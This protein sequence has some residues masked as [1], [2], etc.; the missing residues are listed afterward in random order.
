MVKRV[1]F[2]AGNG[3]VPNG[4]STPVDAFMLKPVIVLALMFAAYKNCPDGSIVKFPVPALTWKGE[5]LVAAK[6]PL[7]ASMLKPETVASLPFNE[8]RNLP[9]GCT[10]SWERPLPVAN[11]EP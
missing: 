4:V 11:G 8:Y 1:A 9:E 2:I 5:P 6:A 3:G 7:P 10:R